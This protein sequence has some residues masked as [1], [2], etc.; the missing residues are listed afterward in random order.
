MLR[1]VNVPI[2][3]NVV[4]SASAQKGRGRS[5]YFE[6]LSVRNLWMFSAHF[7]S[8]ELG[9]FSKFDQGVI[10]IVRAQNFSKKWY[11]FTPDT[12]AYMCVLGG[13]KC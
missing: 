8:R 7:S 13:K 5:Q 2:C 12:H 1:L 3:T 4:E 10:Q 6:K 9:T 11:N